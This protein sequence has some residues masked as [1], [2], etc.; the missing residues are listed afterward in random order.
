MK[1]RT[2]KRLGSQEVL[3]RCHKFWGWAANMCAHEKTRCLYLSLVLI[4]HNLKRNGVDTRA[5]NVNK[6][7]ANKQKQKKKKKT[8]KKNQQTKCKKVKHRNQ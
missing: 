8:N 2:K 3:Q 1:V 6:K 7:N 5:V 4:S